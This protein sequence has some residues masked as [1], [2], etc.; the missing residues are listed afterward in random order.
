[1]NLLVVPR[2]AMVAFVKGGVK[3]RGARSGEEG[4]SGREGGGMPA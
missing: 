1:M 3:G 4:V 2:L